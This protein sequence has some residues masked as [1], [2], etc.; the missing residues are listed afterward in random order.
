MRICVF[1]GVQV[2]R[3]RCPAHH[4]PTAHPLTC[5]KCTAAGRRRLVWSKAPEPQIQAAGDH[6]PLALRTDPCLQQ[7]PPTSCSPTA[8]SLPTELLCVFPAGPGVRKG[9]ALACGG[10]GWWWG[11]GV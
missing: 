4:P 6:T 2:K 9:E 5:Q 10:R 1:S 11:M 7:E 8:R 3:L